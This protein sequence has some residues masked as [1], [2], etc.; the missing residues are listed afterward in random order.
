MVLDIT[1]ASE[2]DQFLADNTY[3]MI[4]FYAT[5]CPP[6]KQIAPIYEALNKKHAI[7]GHFQMGKLDVEKVREI[8]TRY[9]I[10]A[11]PTFMFFKQGK[12]V[13]V[14]SDPLLK[15]ADPK[16]LTAAAE[17]LGGLAKRRAEEATSGS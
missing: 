5:W 12:Q 4:D 16:T 1:S 9:T 13:A 10:S 11:M 17:K 2:F 15:G 14:N 6:C 8:S 7:E 3:V